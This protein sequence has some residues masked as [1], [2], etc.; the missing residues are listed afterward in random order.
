MYYLL[1]PLLNSRKKQFKKNLDAD[2]SRRR[3]EETTVQIRKTKK[4]D[5]LNKRR[6]MGGGQTPFGAANN[7][8][9]SITGAVAPQ[10]IASLHYYS[11]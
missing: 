10:P 7:A 4:E 6:Q 9:S 3:R 2:D 8:N 11:G 1:K 5:R